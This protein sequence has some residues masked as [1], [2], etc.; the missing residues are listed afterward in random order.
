MTGKTTSAAAGAEGF[1]RVKQE[2]ASPKSL[3]SGN[4]RAITNVTLAD[5]P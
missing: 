4:P 3:R 5:G 2:P 1:V